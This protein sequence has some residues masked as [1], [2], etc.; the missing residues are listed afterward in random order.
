LGLDRRVITWFADISLDINGGLS[1]MR[2]VT[3]AVVLTALNT[4]LGFVPLAVNAQI[5]PNQI[6]I[7][8][9]LTGQSSFK[10][11]DNGATLKPNECR[12]FSGSTTFRFYTEYGDGTGAR[13]SLD[14]QLQ[15]G[16]RYKLYATSLQPK[17][18][19]IAPDPIIRT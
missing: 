14:R 2:N 1:K 5:A 8:N 19:N 7:C 16:E 12:N 9:R 10:V 4:L 18:L 17:R 11:N 15:G 13:Y 3:H 6:T